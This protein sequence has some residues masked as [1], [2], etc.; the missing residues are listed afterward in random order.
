[1]LDDDSGKHY[2]LSFP[3]ETSSQAQ[4]CPQADPGQSESLEVENSTKSSFQQLST[5]DKK[6]V[7][8][9]LFLL[10]R[11][12]VSEINVTTRLQ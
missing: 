6:K 3:N 10:D 9:I 8:D 4:P 5:E 11:F 1:M 12:C 2:R 7:E